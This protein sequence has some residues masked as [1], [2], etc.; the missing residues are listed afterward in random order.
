MIP[1]GRHV[2]EEDDIE[3]VVAQLRSGWLTQGTTIGEFEDAV[4]AYV[5]V[6]HAVAVANGTAALHLACLAAGVSSGDRAVTS[7]VSFVASANCVRYAGG[8]VDFCDIERG[9]LNA[10]PQ[11]LRELARAGERLKVVIPVHMAGLPC[12]M[13]AIR[14]AVA[15][16]GPVVVE[17]AAHALGARYRDGS[18]VGSCAHSD[19]TVFSFHP[20]KS[21]ATGEGGMITTNRTDLYRRLLRLRSHGINKV[22]DAYQAP[23]Q[24]HTGGRFNRWYYEMQEL[25]Y[26]FR[27]T[28]IQAAL[29][30]SQLR[31]IERFLA[32]RRALSAAY[33]AAFAGAPAGIR[34]AQPRAEGSARHLFIVRA[35]F[36]KGLPTRAEFMQRLFERGYATQVHYIPIPMHPYYARRGA[37]MDGLPEAR[38]YYAEGLSIPLYAGLSDE[39]QAAFLRAAEASI[40]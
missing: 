16:A 40:R 34:A 36:G 29:G 21:I 12:D 5:G 24:A 37:S 30:V 32:R 19:M 17:D 4:A 33:E 38:A 18:K 3:A 31:K 28:D 22:D 35:P 25:G 13:A 15:S 11:H 26:N 7:A 23:E 14:E 20:V 8:E 1:Y 10:D 39:Q 2:L 27:L 9:T 6:R